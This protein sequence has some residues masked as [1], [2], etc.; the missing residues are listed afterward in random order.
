MDQ[1]AALEEIAVIKRVI[2]ESRE[3]TFNTGREI[4]TWGLL[5]SAAVFA[6]YGALISGRQSFVLWIWIVVIGAGW[7]FSIVRGVRRQA[8]TANLGVKIISSVWTSCGVAMTILGFAGTTTGAISDWA[9][10]PVFATVFGICFAVT[11]IV[12]RLTWVMCIAIAWWLGSLLMFL[13]KSYQ[14]LPIFGI[15]MLLLMVMPGIVF[16]KQ[17]K[18][19]QATLD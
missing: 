6:S 4:I 17:W 5:I 11:A 7:I 10:A 14:D 16:H 3:F 18:N 1:Q 15:M 13:V 8:L 9:I 2:E 12:Q 19:R